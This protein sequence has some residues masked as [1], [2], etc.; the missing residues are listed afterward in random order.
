MDP[1]PKGNKSKNEQMGLIKLKSFYTAKETTDKTKRQPTKW[2]TIL[3]NDVTDKGII[4][5]IY[6]QL[7]Q[8]NINKKNKNQIKNGQKT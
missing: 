6:K 1:S 2:E 7:I 5:N 8:L 4:S 3:V